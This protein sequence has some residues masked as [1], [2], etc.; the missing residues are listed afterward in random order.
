M[1]MKQALAALMAVAMVAASI[2][3]EAK[4]GGSSSSSRSFS[5]SSSSRSYSSPSLS[6]S[7][8]SPSP[9]YRSVTPSTSPSTRLGGGS[10]VGMTRSEVTAQ[11]RQQSQGGTV[12]NYGNVGAYTGSRTAPAPMPAPSRGYAPAYPSYSAPAPRQGYS[13]ATVAGAAVAG[14]AVGALAANA[15]HPSAP[16][17]VINGGTPAPM[18]AA[19]PVA[20][21]QEDYVASPQG[22]YVSPRMVGAAPMMVAPV[23]GAPASSGFGFLGWLFVLLVIGGGLYLMFRLFNRPAAVPAYSGSTGWTMDDDK[24]EHDLAQARQLLQA[25]PSM[26]C[27]LQDINNRGDKSALAEMTTPELYQL[28][29][30]DIDNRAD[31]SQTKV[32]SVSVANGEV[33][34]FVRESDRYLGSIHFRG[35]IREGAGREED[36]NEVW[37]FVRDLSGGRWK[38]AGIEQV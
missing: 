25:A 36:L 24:E 3:A 15:M 9:S 16:V 23:Q 14:A 30:Q 10:S 27:N 26:F 28:F 17:T 13:G 1:K 18:V 6:R 7:V 8:S 35:R 11:A 38:L 20:A 2:P 33:M 19:A 4:L 32:L 34:G 5:S 21:P 22:G 12:K 29:A 37:H 31:P